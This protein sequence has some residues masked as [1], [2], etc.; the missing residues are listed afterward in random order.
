MIMKILIIS[1]G[2]IGIRHYKNIKKLIPKSKIKILRTK[3]KK[4]EYKEE[5]NEKLAQIFDPDL[6]IINSPA[7]K[8][9]YYYKK[10]FNKRRSYFIEKPLESAS[11]RFDK[12]FLKINN[13]FTMI[14]Y[15]LRF[16]NIL[17]KIK[18][19]V[20]KKKFGD[21]KLVDIKVGQYLP[22]WRT[23]KRYQ[24]GVSAKKKLG[25][26]V[27]LELS[28]EIDYATWIFG[29]PKKI[30]SIT[31]KISNLKINVEDIAS[32]IFEYPKKLIQISL[33]FLQR[34]PKMEIKIVCDRATIYADLIN[35]KLTYH[36]EKNPN[37]KKIE[38]SKFKSG[39][40]IY[41]KQ[42]DFLLQ[43]SFKSYNSKFKKNYSLNCYSSLKSSYKLLKLIDK[44]RQSNK[45]NKK[46]K[47]K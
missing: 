33:D 4:K 6:V 17:L 31:K 18:E 44:I 21:V 20:D 26:G 45:L 30:L 37:G 41:L 7:S 19:L 35:Q 9:F 10:F 14:G 29:Y 16:D 43:H 27:L 32:M 15:V 34:T 1:M 22:Y 5:I 2:S 23:N 28:H 38:I 13:K 12:R 46:V 8:H 47:F 36:N 25:G 40:E 39:N 24:D 11:N 3:N 42:M